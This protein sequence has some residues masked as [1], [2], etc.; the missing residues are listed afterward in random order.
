MLLLADRGFTGCDLWRQ[1]A[2][3]GADLLWRV[4]KHV[5]LPVLEQFGDGSYRSQMFD[6]SDI[7]HT[8]TGIPVRVVEYTLTGG[9]MVYRLATTIL[10]PEAAPAAE[11]AAIYTQ[12]WEFE[13]TLDELKTHQGGPGLVLRSQ[14]P[15]GAEQ[16]LYAFLLV[17]HNGIP[18]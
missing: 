17:H 2:A 13:T 7:H 14:H 4:R 1:A 5:V 11:L 6:Q 9:D 12:R 8:R 15:D 16:E 3:T 18:S 10:D